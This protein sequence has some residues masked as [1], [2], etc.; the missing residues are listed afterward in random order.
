[1]VD[2]LW[3]SFSMMVYEY[4]MNMKIVQYGDGV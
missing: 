4:G 1:M 3:K 2:G